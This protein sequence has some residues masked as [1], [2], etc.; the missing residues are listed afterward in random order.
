MYRQGK[1]AEAVEYYK[2]AL[3]INPDDEDAKHNLEFVREEIKR[4]MNQEKKTATKA[5]SATETGSAT[6]AGSGSA[7]IIEKQSRRKRSRA[8]GSRRD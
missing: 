1:L 2:Q 4:R 8:T 3:D 7:T 6:E 5:G